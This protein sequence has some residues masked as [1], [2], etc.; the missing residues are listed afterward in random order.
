MDGNSWA[1]LLIQVPLVGAF[2]WYSLK[3]Q[4]RYQQS[5]DKRD[6]AYLG[7]LEKITDRLD[8]VEDVVQRIDERTKPR[9]T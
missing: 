9:G 4:E 3:S 8:V 5:M 1:S 2:I 7:A 6:A